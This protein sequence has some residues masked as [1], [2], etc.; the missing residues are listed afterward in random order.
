MLWKLYAEELLKIS[1][2][3]TR[4]KE[5]NN[6][7]KEM[8]TE[9]NLKFEETLNLHR[10][11]L[12]EMKIRYQERIESMV[13]DKDRRNVDIQERVEKMFKECNR[14]YGVLTH[15]VAHEVQ[16]IEDSRNGYLDK[17]YTERKEMAE[18]F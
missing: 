9:N 18:T 11:E 7:L 15:K 2:E 3:N 16:L 6:L 5:E 10:L 1:L 4:L 12:N 13:E 17:G 14:L 8:A